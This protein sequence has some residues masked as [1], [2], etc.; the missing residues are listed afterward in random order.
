MKVHAGDQVGVGTY[1]CV[2]CGEEVQIKSPDEKLPDC[3]ECGAT[4]YEKIK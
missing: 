2:I 3:P 1:K 4:T